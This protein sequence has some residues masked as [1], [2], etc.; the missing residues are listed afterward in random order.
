MQIDNLKL[1]NFR[2]FKEKS[3]DFNP[4][5]N[6][7]IGENGVGKTSLLEAL[8]VALSPFLKI[9]TGKNLRPIRKDDIRRMIL[10]GSD[11]ERL[12]CSVEATGIMPEQLSHWQIVKERFS[13]GEMRTETRQVTSMSKQLVNKVIGGDEKVALPL[14][15]YYGPVRFQRDLLAGVREDFKGK[16]SR[17]DTYPQSLNSI[18]SI[19]QFTEWFKRVE[20][21]SLQNKGESKRKAQ[22]IKK[23]I[24]NCVPNWN[25]LRFDFETGHLQAC[26][27]VSNE[28]MPFKLL[29]DGQKTIMGV[30]ADLVYRCI[31]LNPY[32][33][34]DASKETKGIVLI[35]ELDVHLHPNWQKQIVGM[36]R[37]TF[38]KIQFITTT[39]SPFIIQS[40]KNEELID[41]QG[42]ELT[43]DYYRKSIEEIAE[44]EMGVKNV[45]RSEKFNEMMKVAE[46]YYNLL[47]K[48]ESSETNRS[49]IALKNRLDL[50]EQLYNED[51][52]FVAL[53]KAERNSKR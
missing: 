12:F 37:T 14:V 21:A 42:K 15:K 9:V 25:E 49:V 50:L 51:P 27:K 3:F 33:E 5:F 44:G 53:L 43:T 32:F 4:H 11:E 7:I 23:A 41:L 31:I 48:G 24:N 17:F 35:D 46:E 1:I 39:H 18:S 30:V 40:L 8:N 19:V 20:L 16:S 26:N 52:A 6:V 28:W 38:P 34:E 47:E 36:L 13:W 45:E 2:L 29:S 10:Q 22:L